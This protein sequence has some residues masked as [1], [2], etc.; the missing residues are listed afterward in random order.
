[1][2]NRVHWLP[3]SVLHLLRVLL[4]PRQDVLNLVDVMASVDVDAVEFVGH[5]HQHCRDLLRLQCEVQFLAFRDRSAA[6]G[7]AGSV[8]TLAYPM[9]VGWRGD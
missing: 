2:L 5:P 9:L 6:V 4:H 1:M 7:L 3:N 8:A